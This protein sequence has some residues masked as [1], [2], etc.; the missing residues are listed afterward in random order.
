[1]L[2][3]CRGV[4]VESGDDHEIERSTALASVLLT[5]FGCPVERTDLIAAR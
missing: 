2:I 4:F 3:L 5:A 1:M